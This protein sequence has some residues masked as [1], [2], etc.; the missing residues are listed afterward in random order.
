MEVLLAIQT[1]C[2][3]GCYNC[4]NNLFVKT[5]QNHP[6]ASI[7]LP[8]EI[9]KTIGYLI[10][11]KYVPVVKYYQLESTL[12]GQQAVFTINTM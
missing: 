7:L 2:Q 12:N 9:I 5:I 11:V 4:K 3:I 1:H 6:K 10:P 8:S